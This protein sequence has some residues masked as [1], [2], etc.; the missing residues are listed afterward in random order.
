ML[1]SGGNPS[2][3]CQLSLTSLLILWQKLMKAVDSESILT[4]GR[5]VGE[6]SCGDDAASQWGILPTVCIR[7][8]KNCL[9]LVLA[10][11]VISAEQDEHNRH[12]CLL[13]FSKTG[14]L[15]ASISKMQGWKLFTKFWDFMRCHSFFSRFEKLLFHVDKNHYSTSSEEICHW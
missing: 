12:T 4:V 10:F 6:H 13:P 11:S 9:V 15:K 5:S 7:I 14:I 8:W 3:G 1:V 2:P